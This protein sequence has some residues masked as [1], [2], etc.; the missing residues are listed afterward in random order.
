MQREREQLTEIDI[1]PG[2]EGPAGPLPN[3][4][5]LTSTAPHTTVPAANARPSH[6]LAGF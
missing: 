1:K 3:N 2:V 5:D 6:P 4:A